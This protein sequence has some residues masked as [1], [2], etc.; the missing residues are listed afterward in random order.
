MWR[1]TLTH[2]V[3][4]GNQVPQ[5]GGGAVSSVLQDCHLE[6]NTAGSGGGAAY[7][8]LTDCV[9]NQNTS[10][11]HG[12]GGGA[13]ASTLDRCVLTY[14]DATHGA[15][16]SESTLT[17]C[18]LRG[19]RANHGAGAFRGTLHQCRL[20]DNRASD[21]GGGASSATLVSCALVGNRGA[22]GGGV[23]GGTMTNCTLVD[24]HGGGAQAATLYN[25]ILWDNAGYDY[26][27][28]CALHYSCA[29][30][31]AAG[32]GNTDADPQLLPDAFISPAPPPPERRRLPLPRRKDIDGRRGTPR[33]QDV[34]NGI[35]PVTLSPP[36]G[37]PVGPR[38][39]GLTPGSGSARLNSM[40]PGGRASCRLAAPHRLTQRDHDDSTLDAGRRRPLSGRHQQCLWRDH[41]RRDPPRHSLRGC[42]GDRGGAALY[43]LGHGGDVIAG[44]GGCRRFRRVGAGRQRGVRPRRPGGGRRFNQPRCVD[45]TSDLVGHRR[46]GANHH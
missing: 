38:P 13:L 5:E 6:H 32:E 44:C 25:C 45:P 26:W 9:L 22:R 34:M 42:R 46:A 29:R 35:R 41:Q 39:A 7:A 11:A 20:E 3:L 30:P 10:S 15:G 28:D 8:I 12:G 33:L 19:N 18:L 16:A 1:G 37:N 21:T 14:N 40:A 24:C 23:W 4:R 27:M 17:R 36:D 31:R 43:Q 2:T